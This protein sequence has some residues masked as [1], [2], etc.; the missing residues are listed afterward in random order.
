[1]KN[2]SDFV[3]SD[4][5]GMHKNCK[6]AGTQA[7]QIVYLPDSL[8]PGIPGG[9]KALRAGR[10]S[11]QKKFA[12]NSP[13]TGVRPKRDERPISDVATASFS[14]IAANSLNLASLA[15]PSSIG[16]DCPRHRV[17]E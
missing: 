6:A 2:Q 17:A 7:D 3:V 11:R 13:T 16:G 14:D 15:R 12:L 5:V 1:M 9:R 10:A 8:L 4:C